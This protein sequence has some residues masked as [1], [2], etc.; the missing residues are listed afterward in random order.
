MTQAKEEMFAPVKAIPEMFVPVSVGVEADPY[1]GYQSLYDSLQGT[2]SQLLDTVEEAQTA[3]DRASNEKEKYAKILSDS[4]NALAKAERDLEVLE[5][6][7]ETH[8]DRIWAW[9][10]ARGN[11]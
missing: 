11:R 1:S 9:F 4:E 5:S 10:K 8:K 2:A 3:F 6:L 7:W